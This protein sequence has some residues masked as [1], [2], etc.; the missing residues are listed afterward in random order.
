MLGVA[1]PTSHRRSKKQAADR[2]GAVLTTGNTD[3]D[4][5]A[6]VI[7]IGPAYILTRQRRDNRRHR[8]SVCRSKDRAS[9]QITQGV[10]G[11]TSPNSDWRLTPCQTSASEG[12]LGAGMARMRCARA[13]LRRPGAGVVVSQVSLHEEE[14]IFMRCPNAHG[15]E[16]S[17]R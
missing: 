7:E 3:S 4:P 13:E 14:K 9:Y 11:P 12:T 2:L 10:G 5:S 1:L 17:S 6:D 15:P 16:V 8:R